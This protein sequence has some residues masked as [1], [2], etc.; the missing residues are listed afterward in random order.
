M[1][2]SHAPIRAAVLLCLTLAV[3]AGA[4]PGV[5]PAPPGTSCLPRGFFAGPAPYK[6]TEQLA[7]GRVTFRL[8]APN[9]TEALV[10]SSDYAPAIPMGFGGGPPGSR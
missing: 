10:T 8:C 2:L 3:S 4:Q 5:P 6:S 9:A 7:D 1:P